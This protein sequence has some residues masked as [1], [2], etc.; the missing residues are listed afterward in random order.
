MAM[1]LPQ[2]FYDTKCTCDGD[3][4][5]KYEDLPFVEVHSILC[6]K[7]GF[8]MDKSYSLARAEYFMR[9]QG[10]FN[11]DE[12]K[13]EEEKPMGTKIRFSDADVKQGYL[14]KQPNW[15]QY[16]ITK[17]TDK[18]SKAG[19]SQNHWMIFTGLS[20]E[21]KDVEV[22]QNFNDKVPRFSVPF[23]T[24]C[25]GGNPLDPTKDYDFDSTVGIVLEAYTQRG[26]YEGT[27]RNDLVDFRPVKA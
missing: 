12:A 9:E 10:F 17:H 18:A 15:Y 13:G 4:D 25:N 2:S 22:V 1:I 14:V 24:A 27:P 23:F 16:K 19:D 7:Y 26:S 21:M 20:G 5:H 8:I 3:A 6:A 11:N